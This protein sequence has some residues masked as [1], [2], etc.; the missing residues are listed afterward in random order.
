MKSDDDD[1]T[2]DADAKVLRRVFYGAGAV[3][4]FMF[5]LW[6]IGLVGILTS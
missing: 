6:V 3:W 5:S 1:M 4:I 2:E